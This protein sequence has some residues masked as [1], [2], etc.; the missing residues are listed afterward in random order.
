MWRLIA[1]AGKSAKDGGI[2]SGYAL[3]LHLRSWQQATEERMVQRDKHRCRLSRT[4]RVFAKH[5]LNLPA[6]S[7]KTD[8]SV[9]WRI[10]PGP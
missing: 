4:V 10:S 5:R 9:Y 3:G 6:S 1:L 2:L 7:F 8:Y